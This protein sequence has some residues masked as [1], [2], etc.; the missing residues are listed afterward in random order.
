MGK[1]DNLLRTLIEK[2]SK[3][4]HDMSLEGTYSRLTVD[5]QKLE[6]YLEDFHWDESRFPERNSIG[7]DKNLIQQD[8]KRVEN[9]LRKMLQKYQDVHGN[10]NALKRKRGLLHRSG[11]RCRANVLTAPLSTVLREEVVA[12]A[13][14]GLRLQEVFVNTEYLETVVV[15]VSR[16]EWCRSLT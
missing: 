8:M 6:K 5:G 7:E 9:E 15:V 4:Y 10:V 16:C 11:V 13:T 2:I 3:T 1:M 12:K 14:R